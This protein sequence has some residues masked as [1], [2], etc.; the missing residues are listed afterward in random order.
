MPSEGS[1]ASHL[2]HWL[3]AL[4]IWKRNP[5]LGTGPG[6]FQFIAI[7]YNQLLYISFFP[8]IMVFGDTH[9]FL[10][11]I[12]AE[13]GAVGLFLFLWFLYQ[14][15]KINIKALHLKSVCSPLVKPLTA[16]L[17]AILLM[18]LTLND[19]TTENFWGLIGIATCGFILHKK[20]ETER[21]M[22]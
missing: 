14:I 13:N 4:S 9:N 6:T 2:Y 20:G 18:N 5:L 19:Y 21:A 3:T 10:L 12:L 8:K 22:D 17:I 7:N 16:G 1:F 15:L 11:Q